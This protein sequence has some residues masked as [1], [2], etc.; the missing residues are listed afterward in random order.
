MGDLSLEGMAPCIY[1]NPH[2]WKTLAV[3][4]PQIFLQVTFV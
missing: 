3:G 1:Q 2:N 4:D